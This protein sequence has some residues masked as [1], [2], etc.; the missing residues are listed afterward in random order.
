LSSSKFRPVAVAGLGYT[1]RHKAI[2][3]LIADML[4]PIVRDRDAMDVTGQWI[5]MT[6]AIRNQGRPG[7][8][9][10]AIAAVD[11]ALWDL[12]ARLLKIPW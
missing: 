7:L 9:S 8:A 4:S 3:T 6:R 5:A 12:K 1:Y 2:A 10:V 11:A